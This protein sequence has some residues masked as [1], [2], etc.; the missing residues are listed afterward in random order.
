M[1]VDLPEETR[2][3]VLAMAAEKQ[4]P[5]YMALPALAQFEQALIGAQKPPPPK[6]VE[7]PAE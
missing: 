6:Q 5:R 3:I 7:E 2:G 1:I 4:V